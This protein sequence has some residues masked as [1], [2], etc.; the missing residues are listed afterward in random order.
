MALV[1]Y[2]DSVMNTIEETFHK[3]CS[4]FNE[5]TIERIITKAFIS[6]GSKYTS[7]NR[8]KNCDVGFASY[9]YVH[10]VPIV[11]CENLVF[12]C[13][14][15][16]SKY[17][18]KYN[19]RPPCQNKKCL[20][21]NTVKERKRRNSTFSLSAI[22][23]TISKEEQEEI[24][25][26]QMISLL[27]D[28][29]HFGSEY[30]VICRR[31]PTFKFRGTLLWKDEPL[32][33]SPRIYSTLINPQICGIVYLKDNK[34]YCNKS[35]FIQHTINDD[36]D[37]KS[38]WLRLE[39]IT[40]KSTCKCS[41]NNCGK[42]NVWPPNWFS[43]PLSSYLTDP[44]SENPVFCSAHCYYNYKYQRN[45]ERRMENKRIRQTHNNNNK[46]NY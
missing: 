4:S 36:T 13:K 20:L 3:T 31:A 18:L 7:S 6:V 9:N 39:G 16:A 27:F 19:R 5:E 32:G 22:I 44:S 38:N 26:I 1:V 33:F 24:R 17:F 10:L 35:C 37:N 15:C 28:F 46:D 30:N 40:S 34:Y 25:R 14:K 21:G 2:Y 12:C 23:E 43:S 45:Y 29:N 41:F 11:G 8:C 42:T